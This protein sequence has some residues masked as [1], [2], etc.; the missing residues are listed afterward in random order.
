MIESTRLLRELNRKYEGDTLRD[1][2]YEEALLRFAALW[3]E[4]CALGIDTREGTDI[5]MRKPLKWY[6]EQAASW[7]A[8]AAPETA[9][10]E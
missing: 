5:R 9:M 7:T 10:A 1:L 2:S 3:A 8:E 4:A 6:E